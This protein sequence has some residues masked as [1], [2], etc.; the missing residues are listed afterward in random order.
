MF[1]LGHID[2]LLL[3][4]PLALALGVLSLVHK[5]T[6]RK[7]LAFFVEGITFCALF[8]MHGGSVHG[9][10]AAVVA[11]LI[12]GSLFTPIRRM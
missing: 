4:Y 3:L 6:H 1:G 12:V 9:G 11:A 7:Y 5:W 10:F 2:L 8:A